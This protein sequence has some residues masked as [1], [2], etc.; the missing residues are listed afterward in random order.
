[1]LRKDRL[2]ILG[3]PITNRLTLDTKD[4]TL[5]AKLRE[6]KKFVKQLHQHKIIDDMGD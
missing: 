4:E 5:L 6:A 1:M 2:N 3:V